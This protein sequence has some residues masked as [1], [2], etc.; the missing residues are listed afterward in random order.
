M[1]RYEYEFK[2]VETW[3][4]HTHRYCSSYET[5]WIHILLDRYIIYYK[6]R[7]GIEMKVRVRSE[8]NHFVFI[9]PVK[10][11]PVPTTRPLIVVEVAYFP[12]V[13]WHIQMSFTDG[14]FHEKTHQIWAEIQAEAIFQYESNIYIYISQKRLGWI[15]ICLKKNELYTVYLCVIPSNFSTANGLEVHQGKL[16]LI[17]L[18]VFLSLEIPQNSGETSKNS[19]KFLKS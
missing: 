4:K 5:I 7:L 9:R 16:L 8:K 2:N 6:K 13:A 19:S 10:P 11:R 17:I 12:Q 3:G 1:H 18:I 14:I 15:P